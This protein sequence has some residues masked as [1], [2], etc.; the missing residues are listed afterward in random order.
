MM[1]LGMPSVLLVA[2]TVMVRLAPAAGPRLISDVDLKARSQL[3]PDPPPANVKSP[4]I[5]MGLALARLTA[6]PLVLLSVVPP[7]I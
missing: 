3:V 4:L 2:V 5:V 1:A 6:A 7:L